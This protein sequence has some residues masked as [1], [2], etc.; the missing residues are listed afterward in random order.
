MVLADPELLTSNGDYAENP[1]ITRSIFKQLRSYPP[2][3]WRD[4]ERH[5]RHKYQLMVSCHN[6]ELETLTKE[7]VELLSWRLMHLPM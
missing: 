1:R 2:A 6:V 5:R 7:A 4:F 3:T